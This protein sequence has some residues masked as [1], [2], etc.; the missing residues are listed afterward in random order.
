MV[1]ECGTPDGIRVFSCSCSPGGVDNP[2]YLF[3]L[4]L[5]QDMRASLGNFIDLGACY[6]IVIQILCGPFCAHYGKAKLCELF[7]NR[8]DCFFVVTPHTE[9]H[10]P[11]T[12]N[13]LSG[14]NLGFGKSEAQRF[15]E[16]H[17]F[18]CGFHFWA[19]EG[20]DIVKSIE[21]EYRFLHGIMIY[22]YFFGK[23][24]LAECFS[25]HDFCCQFGQGN[26]CGFADERYGPGSSRVDFKDIE[27]IILDCILDIHQADDLEFQG[28]CPCC[29]L[30][31]LDSPLGKTVGRQYA[32]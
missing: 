6:A 31:L 26:P 3:V 19:E 2:L 32:G 17:N 25:C 5:I 16:A 30:D 15:V 27:D 9:K 14:S 18:A 13:R 28:H 22:V 23:S 8:E 24:K 29:F 11:F 21:G 12:G 7:G 20:V 10:S 4:D 1:V